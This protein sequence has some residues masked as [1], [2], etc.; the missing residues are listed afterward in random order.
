M[1]Y[2]A[3]HPLKNRDTN[4]ACVYYKNRLNEEYIFCSMDD[5]QSIYRYDIKTNSWHTFIDLPRTDSYIE[6]HRGCVDAENGK[7]YLFGGYGSLLAVM[8][9][10]NKQI[11]I[12]CVESQM[13]DTDI[14]QKYLENVT[15][16]NMKSFI[17]PKGICIHSKLHIVGTKGFDLLHLNC[18]LS[19]IEHETAFKE[20]KIDSNKRWGHFH[21]IYIESMKQLMICGSKDGDDQTILYCNIDNWK[22]NKSDIKLPKAE[23]SAYYWPILSFQHVLFIFYHKMNQIWC[24]DLLEQKWYESEK[25]FDI[26]GGKDYDGKDY[27]ASY[28]AQV[29]KQNEDIIYV[30]Q[31]SDDDDNSFTISFKLSDAMPI[32]LK[33]KF[34]RRYIMLIHGYIRRMNNNEIPNDLINLITK[35]YTTLL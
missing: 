7:M 18:T 24:C 1:E 15:K 21:L 31:C 11:E 35:F 14:D 5:D 33:S 17:D 19:D 28:W 20:S 16:Y 4:A 27:E 22:W 23:K 6:D 26:S 10:E 2:K 30:I 8:D 29:V 25:I 3:T 13:D 34:V 9:I 32:A 12:K